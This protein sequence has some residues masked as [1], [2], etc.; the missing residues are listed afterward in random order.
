MQLCIYADAIKILPKG[1]L[2]ISLVT[3]PKLKEIPNAVRNTVRK[4]NPDYDLV[5]KRHMKLVPF[6]MD[7]YKNLIVQFPLFIQ[8]YIQ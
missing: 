4:T 2:P 8:L 1:Y 6:D 5:I 3:P 7:N